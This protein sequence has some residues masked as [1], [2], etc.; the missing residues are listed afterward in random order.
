MKPTSH[1]ADLQ[2]QS[3]RTGERG[4]ALVALLS[5]VTPLLVLTAGGL[6]T[7]AGRRSVTVESLAQERMLEAAEAGID[8]AIHAANVG[9]LDPDTELTGVLGPDLSYSVTAT[10]LR[11]D[12]VDNDEDGVRDEEDEAGFQIVSTGVY[13]TSQRRI[14][15]WIR[16]PA[17]LPTPVAAVSLQDPAS[18]LNISGNAFSISGNDHRINGSPG[19]GPSLPGVSIAAPGTVANVISGLTAGQKSRITGAGGAPSVTVSPT[20]QDVAGM[21]S[22]LGSIAHNSLSGGSFT[23]VRDFGTPVSGGWRITHS[24]GNLRLSGNQSGAGILA[25]NGDLE[26][27]GS[28]SFTGL[29]LVTGNVRFQ[30][31]GSAT[32]IRGGILVDGNTSVGDNFSVGGTMDFQYSS[33]AL[34]GIRELVSHHRL[35]GWKEI[36]RT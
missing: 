15:G 1:C 17:T 28:I 12:N 6:L 24:A 30:G 23:G 36:A 8:A 26:I 4:W 35:M 31:G 3:R 11:A 22:N 9:S 34:A 21:V 2:I 5:C 7:M 27:S 14:Q 19:A 13:R 18:V 10:D 16:V 25:I 29:V 32:I 20:V 33:E